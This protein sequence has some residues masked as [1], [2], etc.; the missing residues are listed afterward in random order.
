MSDARR[1]AS[2]DALLGV[3]EIMHAADP[4]PHPP[5]L[6]AVTVSFAGSINEGSASC[7]PAAWNMG[8]DCL[9][10]LVHMVVCRTCPRSQNIVRSHST[11]PA[12]PE[13]QSRCSTHSR[14]A[15]CV[16]FK[17]TIWSELDQTVPRHVHV[18]YTN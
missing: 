16:V 18:Q 15:F 5:E 10:R 17:A 6:D 12:G 9:R 11:D 8:R 1:S 4:S 7:Q 2:L 13:Y 3:V 14:C